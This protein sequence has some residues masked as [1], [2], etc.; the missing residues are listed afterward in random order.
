M[1]E[2]EDMAPP[3]SLGGNANLLKG[4]GS[5][6]MITPFPFTTTPWETS[7]ILHHLFSDDEQFF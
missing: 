5:V 7:L 4:L 6:D 1:G 2:I 3:S